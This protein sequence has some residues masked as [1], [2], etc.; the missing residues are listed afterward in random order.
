MTWTSKEVFDCYCGRPAFIKVNEEGVA[1]MI[2]F[3]HTREA[4]LWAPLPKT[5][6]DDWDSVESPT[7]EESKGHYDAGDTQHPLVSAYLTG[8]KRIRELTAQGFEEQHPAI[9]TFLTEMEK[10]VVLNDAGMEESEEAETLRCEMDILWDALDDEEQ[11][12]VRN[13]KKQAPAWRADQEE[14]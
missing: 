13:W 11:S 6:P 7:R 5:K 10:L 8:R 12:F 3:A 4:G 1:E 2:C 14:D 9:S